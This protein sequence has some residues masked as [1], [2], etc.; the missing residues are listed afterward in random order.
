MSRENVEVVARLY[1]EVL[2][3]GRE[4]VSPDNLEFFDPEIEIRQ[5]E[6]LVGTKGTFNGYGGLRHV[7]RETFE[8]FSDVRFTRKRLIA[9]G[10]QVVAVVEV[11]AQGKGSGVEVRDTIGHVWTLRA[12][13]IVIWQVYWDPAEALEAAGL[14]K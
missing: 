6:S 14:R 12:G 13:R 10:D 7:I 5:S 2:S 1:D 3:R 9:S 11:R 4:A 8:A